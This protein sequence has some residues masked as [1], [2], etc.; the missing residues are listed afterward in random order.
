MSEKPNVKTMKVPVEKT[1]PSSKY[2]FLLDMKPVDENMVGDVYEVENT[3]ANFSRICCGVLP[4]YNKKFPDIHFK[5][6][7]SDD[8]K[9]LYVWR[10][11]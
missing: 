2:R 8:R 5:Y 1:K 3:K 9:T 11:K 6:S 4:R 7:I 10:D